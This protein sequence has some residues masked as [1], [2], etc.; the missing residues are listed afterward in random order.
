MTPIN[1]TDINSMIPMVNYW[2]VSPQNYLDSFGFLDA[3]L[4]QAMMANSME[5][6]GDGISMRANPVNAKN[7]HGK[8]L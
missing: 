8:L 6:D 1:D 5:N 4:D 7:I 3:A 2:P